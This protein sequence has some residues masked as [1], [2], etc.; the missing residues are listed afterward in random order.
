MKQ[1]KNDKTSFIC[2]TM[3]N[4]KI[5]GDNSTIMWYKNIIF[6]SLAF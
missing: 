6:F 2:D 5:L 4:S 3:K 1:T